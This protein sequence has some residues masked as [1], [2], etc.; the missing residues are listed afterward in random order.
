M[1]TFVLTPKGN[2][3]M[4]FVVNFV[5]GCFLASQHKIDTKEY[6]ILIILFVVAQ[7]CAYVDGG[8]NVS[9]LQN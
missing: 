8:N 1:S 9:K 6:W 5:Y 2:N 3:N 4:S 7:V